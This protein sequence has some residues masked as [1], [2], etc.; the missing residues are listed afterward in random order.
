MGYAKSAINYVPVPVSNQTYWMI[1]LDSISVAGTVIPF[2]GLSGIVDTGTSLMVGSHEII[3]YIKLKVG[4][5][6]EDCSNINSLPI[7]TVKI[8]KISYPLTPQQY[9]LQV[10]SQGQTEC[11][12]GFDGLELPSYLAKSIILGDVFI[13]AY[14]TVFD[15]GNSQV[16]FATA[17]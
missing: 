13:R 6:A 14:Y 12:M 11:I 9:V 7:V 4:H 5:V 1:S 3:D 15:Y 17:A 2:L 16:G 8:N 10:T